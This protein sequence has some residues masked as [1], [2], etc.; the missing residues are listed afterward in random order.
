MLTLEVDAGYMM[1]ALPS[2]VGLT[3]EQARRAAESPA[4][5]EALLWGPLVGAAQRLAYAE[6]AGSC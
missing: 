3:E 5:R 6:P 4:R 2:S 1:S